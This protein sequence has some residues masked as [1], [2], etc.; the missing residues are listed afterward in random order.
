M[1]VHSVFIEYLPLD[2]LATTLGLPRPYLRRLTDEG[3]IPSL[4]VNGRLRF[5]EL[6]VREA[7]L[8]LA[9]VEAEAKQAQEPPHEA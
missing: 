3:R 2:A 7:L 5:D 4:N 8:S 9:V 6:Q 1:A